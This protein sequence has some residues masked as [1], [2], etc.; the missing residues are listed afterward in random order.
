MG[1]GLFGTPLYLN[2]K[3]L[4]FSA[5]IIIVYWLPKPSTIA[6]NLVMAFLL[7]TSSYIILAWYDVL[8]DCNDRLKPTLLGWFSK[9]LKPKEYSDQF[10]ELPLKTQKIIRNFDIFILIIV[11][12]T[13]IYPF[14]YFKKTKNKK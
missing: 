1:G 14:L 9:S 5:I 10:N 2:I 8:Y 13:F 6:H 11:L 3:C 12:I 4:I 7:G